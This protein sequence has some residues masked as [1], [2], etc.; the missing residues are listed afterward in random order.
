[1]AER[2]GPSREL[3]LAC[4]LAADVGWSRHQ[5]AQV[6]AWAE[7][8]L[9]LAGEIGAAELRPGL[10]V[11][12]AAA[13]TCS[14]ERIEE[15]TALLEAAVAEAGRHG[16][17]GAAL[18]GLRT[19]FITK[20]RMW[21]AERSQG[22]LD[23]MVTVADRYGREDWRGEIARLYASL[24]A[25]GGGDLEAARLIL[26]ALD[27][28]DAIL[29]TVR[30][31]M[32]TFMAAQLAL[33]AGPEEAAP[34]LA[35][36]RRQADAHRHPHQLTWVAALETEAAALRSCPEEVVGHVDVLRSTL[37]R[38]DAPFLWAFWCDSWFSA[39][40][41]ALRAGIPPEAVRDWRD[42]LGLGPAVEHVHND[43]AWP[44][45]LDAALLERDAEH[46]EAVEAY[47]RALSGQGRRR[48]VPQAAD[49]RQGLARCLL[50]LGRHEEAR[51][52]AGEAVALLDRWPGWRQ[53]EAGALLRRLGGGVAPS[54]PDSLSARERE[55]AALLAEG[56]TNTDLARR[57]YISPK[58]AA[59]HVSH[60]LTKL[61]M[62]SRAEVAAWA[63]RVGLAR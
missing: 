40:T 22:V 32:T 5:S 53:A 42:G 30:A 46:S 20:G 31:R 37:R 16:D 26:S 63:V 11:D 27:Y 35:R 39:L 15:G 9:A 54:G 25:E 41:A 60:I 47:R 21:P 2:L 49:V 3:V 34:F 58:T 59:V 6:I 50:A 24:L 38:P 33:E 18:R 17:G 36:A 13:I 57:L 56:L 28:D 62:S 48:W 4:T 14:P 45:H 19:L 12:R 55:V 61:G 43:P 10:L 23:E 51:A 1:V 29:D 7:R 8:G 44:D 52:H